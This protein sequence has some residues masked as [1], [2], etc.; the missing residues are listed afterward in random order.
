MPQ[1][2]TATSQR[3]MPRFAEFVTLMAALMALTAL[4]IDVMLPALP[5]MRAEFGIEDANLQQLVLTSYVVGF[6]VGQLFHG[7]LSDWL[8]RKPVLLV[9]LA[10]FA[11][12]SFLCLAASSFEALLAARFLQGLACAA[13]RVVAVAVVRD[14]YGGRRMAE[15]MS[16]VMMVFIVVPV[17][18]PSLGSG[19]MLFGSWHLIFGFLCAFA[20]AVLAWSGLRLP[21]THP[22]A[23]REPMSL[24]WVARAFGQAMTTPQTCGYTLATGVIFG[25]LMGYINSAQ[26]IFV[27]T[28][29]AGAWFPVLFGCVAV[30]LAL[31]AF[32][33]S[34]FVMTLG[35]RRVSHAALLG[36]CATTVLHLGVDLA[37]GQ[38][39]LALFVVLM[40]LTLFCFGLIMPNFNALAMEPMG[41][42]AGTASSF[43]G[44]VTTGLGAALGLW[45]GQQYDGSVTPL[46]VGFAAF[47]LAGLAI[48]LVTERG[49]LFRSS[50]P[51]E[52]PAAR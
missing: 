47:G 13:P 35:M 15:V 23:A 50:R 49:R 11:L 38:P 46:L 45:V 25:S 26:Q 40:A 36:F 28:Y 42:I 12:A 2:A 39:P 14:T 41:R 24:G 18:A 21:E 33:N 51:A 16:L 44:A 32:L 5:Q 1:A 17:V 4:S 30:T 6:A 34:R 7:P 31:S 22:A 20:L 48:V 8:G 43:F 37:A 19:V 52:A 3:P 27:E 10:V 29:A 9:G